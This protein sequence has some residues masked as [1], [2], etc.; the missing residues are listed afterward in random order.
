MPKIFDLYLFPYQLHRFLVRN[1]SSYR[2]KSGFGSSKMAKKKVRLFSPFLLSRISKHSY[3]PII[4]K[5]TAIDPNTLKGRELAKTSL[6][7][8]EMTFFPCHFSNSFLY[9]IYYFCMPYILMY[10]RT[11]VYIYRER[12]LFT[13]QEKVMRRASTSSF[14]TVERTSHTVE[15]LFHCSERPSHSV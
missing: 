1:G 12:N 15:R 10:A 8:P 3:K 13:L 4:Y 14:H 6:K 11:L 2:P 7:P 5:S 9:A